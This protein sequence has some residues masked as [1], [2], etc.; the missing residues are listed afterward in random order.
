V[1]LADSVKT[2]LRRDYVRL[3]ESDWAS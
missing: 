1:E 2:R 3:A